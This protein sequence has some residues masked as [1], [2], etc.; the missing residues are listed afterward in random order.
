MLI[1]SSFSLLSHCMS[2][3]FFRTLIYVKFKEIIQVKINHMMTI[4]FKHFIANLPVDEIKHGLHQVLPT[5]F[6]FSMSKKC[7]AAE[8]K[9]RHSAER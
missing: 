3:K 6:L 4:N 1:G 8:E 5:P 2:R 7:G 9:L